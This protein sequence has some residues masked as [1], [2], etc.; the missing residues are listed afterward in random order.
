MEYRE[1]TRPGLI[2]SALAIGSWQACGWVNS[3]QKSF[4]NL[5]AQ[6]L[7]SGIN[8]IDTAEGYANG[9]S[10][11]LIARAIKGK[12]EKLLLSTKFS[13]NHSKPDQIRKSLEKSLRRLRTD[14]IDIY[15]QH[16]PPKSPPLEQTIEALV[17]LRQEGKIR[18]LGVSNWMEPEWNE[19]TSHAHIDTV[20]NCYNLLW[21]PIE[22]RVIKICQSNQISLMAYSPLCQGVLAGVYDDRSAIPKDSRSKNIFLSE[23]LFEKTK[24]L[25]KKLRLVAEKYDKT[26]AQA[27]LR[28]LLQAKGVTTVLLGLSRQEQLIENLG[29]LGWEMSKADWEYLSELTRSISLNFDPHQ[30]LW[31]WHPRTSKERHSV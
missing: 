2:V 6:A 7:D 13:F 10:E 30:S 9:A 27:A 21:R 16:W 15:Q 3:D 14:Y 19:Y 23:N 29:A 11:S 20:Q 17:G 18:A 26:P 12:R 25:L 22:R 5:L 31:G 8:L 28:W 4:T 24:S 1:I